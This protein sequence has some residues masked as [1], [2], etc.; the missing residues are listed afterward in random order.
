[1]ARYV[2]R[3]LLAPLIRAVGGA[4]RE[5]QAEVSVTRPEMA[6]WKIR[7][8]AGFEVSAESLCRLSLGAH[9]P[10]QPVLDR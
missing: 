7:S 3:R 9:V 1:M 6:V 8:M 2:T 5:D 4:S 10:L